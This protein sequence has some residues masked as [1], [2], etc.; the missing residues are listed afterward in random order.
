MLG[1]IGLRQ[2]K[3]GLNLID[4]ERAMTKKL[5]DLK[6]LGAGQGLESLGVELK[7][8]LIHIRYIEYIIYCD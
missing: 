1:E 2:I 5:D 8:L 6:S 7:Y 4:A 3:H